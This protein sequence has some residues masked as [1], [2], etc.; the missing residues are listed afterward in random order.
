LIEQYD[1]RARPKVRSQMPD[2]PISSSVCNSC[3]WSRQHNNLTWDSSLGDSLW[4][5]FSPDPSSLPVVRYF[6]LIVA[7]CQFNSQR[8]L[9]LVIL[10]LSMSVFDNFPARWDVWLQ[11]LDLPFYNQKFVYKTIIWE[12]R[13]ETYTWHINI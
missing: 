4:Y 12:E 6:L 11:R 3:K 7:W 10:N 9:Y 5:F 8:Y 13:F 1:S 2:R